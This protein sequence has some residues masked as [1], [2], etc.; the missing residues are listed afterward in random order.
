MEQC[1]AIPETSG[2]KAILKEI[3]KEKTVWE[4]L[5]YT[6]RPIVLYGTGNGGDKLID[7]L[8]KIGRAPA[9]VFASDGFVRSR[10]FHDMPVLSLADAEKQFGRDMII[11]CAFGS[12]VPEV[13]EH[14]RWLDK[15]YN[16]YMPEL[17]LYS[18]DLFDYDYFIKHIDDIQQAYSLLTD[19]E[20]Q[21][22]FC[23]T[24]RYRL[25]GRIIH[26]DITEHFDVSLSTLLAVDKIH[27]ALDGG[28]Y[29]GDTAKQMMA[30]FPELIE[31]IAAEPD[32]RTFKKL[33]AYAE[34]SG[35]IVCPENCA[36]ASADGT[37]IFSS[38]G[39]RGSGI[40]GKNARAKT[41]EIYTRTVD[42]LCQN[43]TVDLIKLDVE[44]DE[45]EA[46]SAAR[47]TIH[48]SSPALAISLYHR[49]ED[50]FSLPLQ[51]DSICKGDYEYYLRRV[52]CY[53]AWDLMLYAIP[54]RLKA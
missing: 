38:S 45:S 3:P 35:G 2:I 49:T 24:I 40:A 54:T 10:M 26:L 31:L 4:I 9:G 28:A 29:N 8:A 12:S 33:S 13:M 47:E 1:H 50:I 7:A 16:F 11:L 22:I 48:R 42:T 6:D 27:T 37:Y 21:F 23:E 18:G 39:S 43:K 36:L 19:A 5:R 34:T 20:S 51:A 53:P 46:L 41:I 25:S 32:T 44:G 17:P 14:M 30:V 15:N 52:P